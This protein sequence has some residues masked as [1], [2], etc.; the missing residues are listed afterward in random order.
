MLLFCLGS[1]FT[2]VTKTPLPSVLW[3]FLSPAPLLTLIVAELSVALLLPRQLTLLW[4][5]LTVNSNKI[6]P[7]MPWHT[8]NIDKIGINLASKCI[9]TNSHIHSPLTKNVDSGVSLPE[10]EALPLPSCVTLCKLLNLSESPIPYLQNANMTRTY[11]IRLLRELN[12]WI[13]CAWHK[14]SANESVCCYCSLLLLLP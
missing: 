11:L 12:G 13:Y 1:C 3:P 9:P 14:I 6:L 4:L 10:F 7:R 5:L 2:F 8:N